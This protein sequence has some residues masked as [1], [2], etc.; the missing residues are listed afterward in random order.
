M[1]LNVSHLG[2]QARPTRRRCQRI[3]PACGTWPSASKSS[4]QPHPVTNH[5]TGRIQ[6]ARLAQS[7]ERETLNLKVVGSTRKP[8][9]TPP[10]GLS[11][12]LTNHSHV[13]LN[14]RQRLTLPFF[15]LLVILRLLL[16]GHILVSLIHHVD[17]VF[18]RIS[19]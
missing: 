2:R 17:P 18:L 1:N 14:S 9:L 7:V 13:G 4:S 10:S 8:P 5:P 19:Q 6:S 12:R 16:F 15:L 3:R 11:P